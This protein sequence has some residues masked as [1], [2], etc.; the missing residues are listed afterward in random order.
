MGPASAAVHLIPVATGLISGMRLGLGTI[1]TAF[2]RSI[3]RLQDLGLRFAQC[4][5]YCVGKAFVLDRRRRC[6]VCPA[7]HLVVCGGNSP[8]LHG[9][10]Q[11]Q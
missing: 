4:V 3:S 8:D 11:K 7:S 9:L 10:L 6:L 5:C 1:G 2:R